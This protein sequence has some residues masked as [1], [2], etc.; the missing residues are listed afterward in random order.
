MVTGTRLAKPAHRH[1]SKTTS[2]VVTNPMHEDPVS[3]SKPRSQGPERIAGGR[4]AR[5]PCV[6]LST[7][8]RDSRRQTRSNPEDHRVDPKSH[9][10]SFQTMTIKCHLLSLSPGTTREVS[11]QSPT[12]DQHGE[13]CVS[14]C[15]PQIKINLKKEELKKKKSNTQLIS[16]RQTLQRHSGPPELSKQR[17]AG[18]LCGRLAK[19]EVIRA[20]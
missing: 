7:A 6:S 2:P 9:S 19:F 12:P 3:L 4:L 10:P 15:G 1:H 17:M 18:Q 16:H 8:R 13:S 20:T 14:G 5:S 11:G